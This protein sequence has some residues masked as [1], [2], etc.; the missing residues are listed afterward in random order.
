MRPA[1]RYA[2]SEFFQAQQVG[3][4]ATIATALTVVIAIVSILFIRAQNAAERKERAG[5]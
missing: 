5:L 3:Y 2:Y 4:G 1:G